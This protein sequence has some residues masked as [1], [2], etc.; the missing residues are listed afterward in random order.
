M[1][2]IYKGTKVGVTL[3]G[4]GG[5]GDATVTELHNLTLAQGAQWVNTGIDVSDYDSFLFASKY[6][7]DVQVFTQLLKSNIV[8]YTGTDVYTFIFNVEGKPYNVRIYNGYLYVSFNGTGSSAYSA[9]VCTPINLTLIT[10][11]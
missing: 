8:V 4:S 3:G 9:S 7:D 6:N 1:S 2:I 5:G 10:G 11:S